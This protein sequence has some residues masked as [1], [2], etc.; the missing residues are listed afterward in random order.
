VIGTASIAS[1]TLLS[2]SGTAT[3]SGLPSG[4]GNYYLSAILWSGASFSYQSVA[5][6]VTV[7]GGTTTQ[8]AVPL[9]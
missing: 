4:S 5:S 9:N 6:P 1:S 3:V 7:S 2:G 8:V